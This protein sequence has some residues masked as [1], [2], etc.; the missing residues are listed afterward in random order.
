V[1]FG[2]WPQVSAITASGALPVAVW[3]F[4]LGVYLVV[5]GFRSSPITDEA[6]P[7]QGLARDLSDNGR[8]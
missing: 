2:F 3:E 4:S 8:F 5:K 6:T 7:V 1:L